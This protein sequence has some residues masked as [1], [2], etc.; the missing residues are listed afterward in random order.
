MLTQEMR[1]KVRAEALEHM[2]Q[3]NMKEPVAI[4]M[5]ARGKEKWPVRITLRAGEYFEVSGRSTSMDVYLAETY[6]GYLVSILNFQSFTP[7]TATE[8]APGVRFCKL[9]AWRPPPCG[10]TSATGWP[11]TYKR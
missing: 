11:S 9:A 3:A 10:C 4:V 5:A 8:W 7:A 6:S 2:R 1:E